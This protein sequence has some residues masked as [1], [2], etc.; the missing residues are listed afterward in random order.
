MT[1]SSE[2]VFSIS[3]MLY[4]VDIVGNGDC[5]IC[6]ARYCPRYLDAALP[7]HVFIINSVDSEL[8][9]W[10]A[11]KFEFFFWP[12]EVSAFQF[13]LRKLKLHMMIMLLSATF[14]TWGKTSVS[15]L[16]FFTVYLPIVRFRQTSQTSPIIYLELFSSELQHLCSRMR[17]IVKVLRIDFFNQKKVSLKKV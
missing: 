7:A 1:I 16:A 14:I 2:L 6:L 11:R 5:S 15:L 12:H 4:Y 8:A 10:S 9:V 17:K 13:C 3:C